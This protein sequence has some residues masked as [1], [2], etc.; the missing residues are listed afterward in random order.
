MLKRRL[1]KFLKKENALIAVI[2]ILAYLLRVL[3]YLLGYPIP[4]TEDGIRDFQQVQYLVDNHKI[5]FID[6][7]YNYGA[8]PV[9]HLL[10]FAVSLIG[11]EPIKIFLFL[12]QIFPC[13]GILFFYLFLRKHFSDGISLLSCFLLSVFGPHI[14]WSSQPVRETVGLFFFP[15]IIYLFDKEVF[16]PNA[17][18]SILNKV[19]VT[20]S[21]ILIIL[22]HHW[23]NIM[24]ICWLLFY[25]LFFLK[26][27]KKL[28][29]ALSMTAGFL[30]CTL[31]YWF[32]AFRLAFTLIITPF[33]LIFLILL[34]ITAAFIGGVFL[35]RRVDLNT[36]KRGW[37]FSFC[38]LVLF[39][40]F[41]IIFRSNLIPLHYPFQ[42]W[43]MLGI[44]LVL[45][46]IGFFFTREQKLNDIT[47]INIFYLIFW[48]TA[49]AFFVFR[50]KAL[51]EMPFDPYRTLE[52]SIFS[53]APIA[54]AG[55]LI[56]C[57]KIRF[58]G[59]IMAIILIFLATLTYPPIFV[60]KN[61]FAGT[62]FYD[63]RSDIRYISKDT[64][65]LMQ[66]ANEHGYSVTSN[67]PEIRSYQDTFYPPQE[68]KVVMI[69]KA[70]YVINENY[71]YIKDPILR[72]F[73]LEEWMGE[74]DKST[75]IYSNETGYLI[76]LLRKS[77]FV[78]Q[79]IPA[80]L[81]VG[82]K[83]EVSITIKNTGS[84]I[85]VPGESGHA[86]GS[87]NPQDNHIWGL[88]RVCP[89]ERVVPGEKAKFVFKIKAPSTPGVYNFQWRMLKEHVE[90]F[91]EFTPNMEI[92]VVSA[93]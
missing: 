15:L 75:I 6:S 31:F 86:L 68:E 10:V 58:F 88:V 40:F 29:Y 53:V 59:Q 90:W 69:T 83:R 80:R 89:S 67:I 74:I 70:D 5:N 93:D 82:Q 87:Q 8:F 26:D 62:I 9:L 12:P 48:I 18:K 16:G 66:W 35:V 44:F 7:Y 71:R 19:L 55:F 25:S 91:G 1:I 23:S 77:E 21:M 50:G 33:K 63:V 4:F 37:C 41:L 65:D 49:I 45:S 24:V 78:S 17:G 27:S 30:F 36:M 81:T 32:F 39:S 56:I 52:F 20:I 28:S 11:F 60:Y 2:V 38:L 43:M 92:V 34:I 13:L 79:D 22:S 64:I 61:T 3:P 72:I 54:A 51:A 76:P 42:L 46:L 73:H 57:K 84:E 85:W 47:I 14:H